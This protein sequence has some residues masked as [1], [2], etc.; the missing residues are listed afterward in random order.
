MLARDKS[1]RGPGLP[2]GVPTA[3]VLPIHGLGLAS[4]LRWLREAR[5]ALSDVGPPART[6]SVWAEVAPRSEGGMARVRVE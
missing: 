3:I 5:A 4:Y 6:V 1:C 2:S